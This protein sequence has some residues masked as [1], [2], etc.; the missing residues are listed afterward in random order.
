MNF[1]SL[2]FRCVVFAATACSGFCHAKEVPCGERYADYFSLLADAAPSI[3]EKGDW[4]RGEIE[5]IIDPDKMA[6]VERS[7]GRKVGVVSRDKYWI[8]LNDAVRFP[9]GSY[10]VYGR[11]LWTGSLKGENGVAVMCTTSDGS[12]VLNCNYRHAT[13]S[14]ELE[15]PRGGA[16][17]GE[18]VWD[19]AR[20]EVLEETG[21]VIDSMTSLGDFAPDTGVLGCVVPVL[22][23]KVCAKKAATPE[24]SEAIAGVVSFKK[25][26]LFQAIREGKATVVIG[27]R[28]IQ[29][30]VR[31]PFLTF[32]LLQAQIRGL[33]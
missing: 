31:D 19:A 23:A 12:V 4:K 17:A 14:W 26:D 5:I 16:E 7:T 32:A 25:G 1:A 27:G 10:G 30:F 11:I 3:Q 8:W 9:N 6:D 13:R 22:L 15:L 21:M 28:E 18:S 33:Y 29:A 24:V 2:I 20:R